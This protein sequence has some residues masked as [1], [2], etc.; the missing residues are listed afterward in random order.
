V[1]DGNE[2][3]QQFIFIKP[4]IC[5]FLSHETKQQFLKSV[6]RSNFSSKL[7]GLMESVTVFTIEMQENKKKYEKNRY[8]VNL[9][10]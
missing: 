8:L 6:D 10:I 9:I 3:L 1:I 5:F 4:P 7:A 2:R